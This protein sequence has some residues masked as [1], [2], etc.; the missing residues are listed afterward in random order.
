MP[1]YLVDY[2]G[3]TVSGASDNGELLLSLIYT[4]LELNNPD[5]N[6]TPTA[7]TFE[8]VGKLEQD[9]DIKIGNRNRE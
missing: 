2:W 3:L 4:T 8:A 7:D 9:F 1:C 5:P 6:L